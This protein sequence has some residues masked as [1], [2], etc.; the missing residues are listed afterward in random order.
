MT[1]QVHQNDR[2]DQSYACIRTGGGEY[3]IYDQKLPTAWIQSDTSNPVT[4]CL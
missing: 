4:E 2:T 1:E 3:I